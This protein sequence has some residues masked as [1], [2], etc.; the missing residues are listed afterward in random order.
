MSARNWKNAVLLSSSLM[1]LLQFVGVLDVPVTL[2]RMPYPR[3]ILASPF[4]VRLPEHI[5]DYI[6]SFVCCNIEFNLG[7]HVFSDIVL[8]RIEVLGGVVFTIAEP[9]IMITSPSGAL[10]GIYTCAWLISDSCDLWHVRSLPPSLM[11]CLMVA[12]EWGWSRIK[13][14]SDEMLTSNGLPLFCVAW[15][16]VIETASVTFSVRHTCSN[17]AHYFF[18]CDWMEFG[19][20]SVKLFGWSGILHNMGWSDIGEWFRELRK[21]L[22]LAGVIIESLEFHAAPQHSM[23]LVKNP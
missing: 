5:K 7:K 21:Y 22:H 18:K 17:Q 10:S 19:D 9:Y 20:G 11:A 6:N 13:G 23:V 8:E 2:L 3:L 16:T 12:T 14:S 15:W 1:N 4:R